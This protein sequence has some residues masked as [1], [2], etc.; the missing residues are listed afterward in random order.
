MDKN[1]A[2][3]TSFKEYLKSRRQSYTPQG[4]FVNDLQ[5][6]PDFPDPSTWAELKGYLVRR[7]AKYGV[8]EAARSV[9]RQY[10][11]KRGNRLDGGG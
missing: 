2:M 10:L 8:A 1:A 5:R 9:W 11:L 6:D 4:D 7:G 3:P